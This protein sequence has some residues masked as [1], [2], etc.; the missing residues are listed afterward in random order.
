VQVQR[1]GQRPKEALISFGSFVSALSGLRAAGT[2]IEAIGDNLANL[3]T[4]G[5]K[6]SSISFQDVV[7][8]V[9]G[10]GGPKSG[11]GVAAPLV[12][13]SFGQGSIQ[14]TQ[15]SLDAAIQGDGFFV[16][17]EAAAGSPVAASTDP[18]TAIYTRAGNFRINENGLLVTATGQRVQGWS[19][20][21]VSGQLS[22]SDPIGDIIV[23]VGSNRA[24][25]AATSFNISSNLDASASDGTVFSTPINLYDSLGNAHVVSVTF[26]KTGVNTW[27]ANVATTDQA[28]TEITPAGP[29]K[30]KFDA[31]GGLSD[32]SGTG[33]DTATGLIKDIGLTLSNGAQSPQKLSWSPWQ[34]AP[35]GTPPV[36]VGRISQFS[37]PS[38]SSSIFQ[39]GLPAAQLTGVSIAKG[40]AVMAQ[41]S[42]GSQQEVARISMVSIRNPDTLVSVGN[43]NYHTGVGSAIP[44]VGEAG[45]GGRGSIIG[46]SLEGSNVDIANEFTKLIIFQ[47]SYSA[48]ARVVTTTDEISQ[49]TINIKR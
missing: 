40:G 16:V 35:A 24:A 18:S 44:V 25:K 12:L 22:P 42:N 46:Q 34:T 3:N 10:G 6:G 33:Y 41:Y 15:G 45:S 14:T 2:A 43:N 13:K 30:F 21:T 48:S 27:D 49:E 8:D 36:G 4:V 38:A 7:A 1:R 17:R 5:F 47:R 9:T 32:V 39:D 19:L 11:S 26:T 31:N 20:N 23:P 28:I 37:Q 29:W